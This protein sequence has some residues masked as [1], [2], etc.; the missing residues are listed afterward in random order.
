MSAPDS[1]DSPDGRTYS[2]PEA[3]G[4]AL[5]PL[6]PKW[7]GKFR[8]LATV[9]AV[10]LIDDLRN[11]TE[12]AAWIEANGGH[13]EIPFA[14]PCLYIETPRGRKRAGIGDWVVRGVTGE[15]FPVEPDAFEAAYEPANV[16]AA[17]GQPETAPA[18]GQ[19]FW[20]PDQLL[21]AKHD[22]PDQTGALV[23]WEPITPAPGQVARSPHEAA[24]RAWD[25]TGDWEM[26][27]EAALAAQRMLAA[28]A[29]VPRLAA[30]PGDLAHDPAYRAYEAYAMAAPDDLNFAEWE[31]LPEWQRHAIA[32]SA[33]EAYEVRAA[34]EAAAAP[35][36]PLD[37]DAAE[38][39]TLRALR[40]VVFRFTETWGA[41]MRRLPERYRSEMSCRE[42]EAAADLFRAIGDDET[43]GAIIDAHTPY[44]DEFDRADHAK[45]DEPEDTE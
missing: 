23:D 10:Q 14:E 17:A 24:R 7:T 16:T 15:F 29:P 45:R 28:A 19:P 12:V 35:A 31:D 44:D 27:V 5:P 9:E 2:A 33:Q 36:P 8:V 41:E 43:A 13:A 26:A 22:T 42:A 4:Q 21:G 3:A 25:G 30:P 40:N 6:P 1:F 11:H 34:Q 37:G 38:L 39:A 18:P 32:A 20:R